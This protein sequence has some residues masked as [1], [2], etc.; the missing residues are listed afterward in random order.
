M[1]PCFHSNRVLDSPLFYAP[2]WCPLQSARDSVQLDDKRMRVLADLNEQLTQLSE[3]SIGEE[4]Y[5]ALRLCEPL[6][7]GTRARA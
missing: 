7:A 5:L 1:R 2:P 4:E 6:A 3:P